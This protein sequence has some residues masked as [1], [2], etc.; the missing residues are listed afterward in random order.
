MVIISPKTLPVG[1]ELKKHDI[2][3]EVDSNQETMSKKIR[4]GELQ[5][6]PY[7]LIVGDRELK[8]K[9]VSVRQRKKRDLEVMKLDDFIVKIKQEIDQKK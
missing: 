4:N 1:N 5:K 9:T 6:I 3:V 2:R 8:A 7:L